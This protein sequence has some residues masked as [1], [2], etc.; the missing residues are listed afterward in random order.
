MQEPCG[1]GQYYFLSRPRRFGK[2]LLVNTLKELFE[3]NEP[4]FRGLHIHGAWDWSVQHPVIRLSFGY[5]HSHDPGYV[6]MHVLE[7]LAD[8][9]EAAGVESPRETGPGRLADL[10]RRLHRR[11]AHG[12]DVLVDEC[13]KPIPVALEEPEVARAN[14]D[15]LRGLY[16]VFEECD[17]EIRF[18][19]I[20]G[21]SKFSKVSLFSGLNNLEDITLDP[22]YSS[23]C[24]YTE[25]DL[26]EVFAPQM[27]GLDREEI[28]RW[29]NGYSWLGGECVYNQFDILLLL[30][31]RAFKPYWVETCTPKFL[32]ELL[33][34]R[35]VSSLDLERMA[36]DEELLSKFDV[37]EVGTEALLF[38]TGHLTITGKERSGWK[39]RYQLGYPNLEVRLALNARLHSEMVPEESWRVADHT[40]LGNLLA[41]GDLAGLKAKLRAVFASI[42]SDW[43]RWNR[44]ARYEG[45]Y[46][47]VVHAWFTAQELDV[48]AE[49]SGSGGRADMV[50]PH[51]NAVYVFGF[52]VAETARQG[53][54]LA[55]VKAGGYAV[56][57]LGQGRPVY[58]VGVEFGSESRNVE[59][60]DSERIQ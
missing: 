9:A 36:G 50:V 38:K 24:G 21:V 46:A 55:Q 49:D 13:D 41:A 22:L 48:V 19:F 20:T 15:F 47:A 31:K 42:P 45:Y 30:K 53:T 1:G 5:G 44:I 4:L 16:A 23:I 17:E 59:R 35:R 27:R 51:P 37:G 54:A 3:G 10:I 12:M 32:P 28:R 57:H 14:R 29:Y 11:S 43:H 25:A 6:H 26:D 40:K 33:F 8:I 34:R 56:K 60:F 39:T 18:T 58:L 7:Q 52:K 2:S